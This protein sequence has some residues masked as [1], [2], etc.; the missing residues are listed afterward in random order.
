MLVQIDSKAF[1]AGNGTG[2]GSLLIPIYTVQVGFHPIKLTEILNIFYS[3]KCF[4]ILDKVLHF[5]S[6]P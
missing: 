4:H 3:T 1:L 2:T 6:F 5:F